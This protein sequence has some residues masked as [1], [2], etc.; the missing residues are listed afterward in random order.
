MLAYSY[1]IIND[2]NNRFYIGVRKCH[3]NTDIFGDSYFGSG[4]VIKQAIKKDGLEH[5]IKEFLYIF[6]SFE[7]ALQWEKD[8]VTQRFLEENPLCYNL[9]PGGQG[10]SFPGEKSHMYGRKGKNC[11]NYGK[12]SSDKT[13]E[14]LSIR[15]SGKNHPNWKGGN[16][17]LV[18]QQC[19][20][21]YEVRRPS[22]TSKYCSLKCAYAYWVR[23]K[24][25]CG[26]KHPRWKPRVIVICQK[27][28]IEYEIIPS[29]SKTRKYCSR[30]C[31]DRD[32]GKLLAKR[33]F[34][35]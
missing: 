35:K 29:L 23:F 34:N 17:A 2:V 18:C 9:H 15:L 30:E 11:H 14:L 31:K 22:A 33:E 3:K 20:K 26:E 5:F 19:G 21:N 12:H 4:K 28:G 27:C 1:K 6:S 25:M 8:V 16:I 7:E 32:H 13:R 24:T 10:G